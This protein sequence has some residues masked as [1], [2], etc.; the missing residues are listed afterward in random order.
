MEPTS[1]PWTCNRGRAPSLAADATH[2]QRDSTLELRWASQKDVYMRVSRVGCLASIVISVVLSVVLT[3]ILN[4]VLWSWPVRRPGA[5]QTFAARLRPNRRHRLNS[6][7]WT[8]VQDV[9]YRD[10]A[11]ALDRQ[12]DTSKTSDFREAVRTHRVI[13]RISSSSHVPQASLSTFARGA[14]AATPG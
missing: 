7:R 12:G 13:D 9:A 3:V 4:L 1:E 8:C 6:W 10:A 14:P 11:H 2:V 5:R